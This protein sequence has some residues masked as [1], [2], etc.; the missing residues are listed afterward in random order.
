MKK[1][2][3]AAIL[4]LMLACAAV[5]AAQPMH[6]H[7]AVAFDAVLLPL[8]TVNLEFEKALPLTN[9]SAGLSGWY[10]YKEV[11]ARWAYGKLLYYPFSKSLQ[12]LALGPL[13]GVL[14]YYRQED[15]VDKTEKDTSL[16]LGAI[17]QY[18]WLL[19]SSDRFLIGFG[20]AVRTAVKKIEPA[21]PLKRVDG[22][23][24]LVAGMTF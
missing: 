6:H 1:V 7:N 11:K 8:G 10:E 4:S 17:G 16:M 5:V 13:A 23:L 14:R 21:S 22:E 19:G 3:V 15:Q 20:L 12:G 2:S 18:N 9:L 24:R